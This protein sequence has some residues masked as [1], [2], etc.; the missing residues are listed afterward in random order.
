MWALPAGLTQVAT[1]C[2]Q[3]SSLNTFQLQNDAQIYLV[4]LYYVGNMGDEHAA[5]LIPLHLKNTW[6]GSHLLLLMSNANST[7]QMLNKCNT[8]MHGL[9]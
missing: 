6:I 3:S 2:A 1:Y 9:L 4:Y 7:M 8:T 5:E